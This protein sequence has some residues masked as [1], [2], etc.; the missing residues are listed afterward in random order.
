MGIFIPHEVKG[1]LEMKSLGGT[2]NGLIIWLPCSAFVL[3][4]TI[5]VILVNDQFGVGGVFLLFFVAE[6]P[7]QVYKIIY[8]GIAR[9]R[10]YNLKL[11]RSI[12]NCWTIYLI[13]NLFLITGGL[14][15]WLLSLMEYNTLNIPNS[16]YWTVIILLAVLM[17]IKPIQS[18]AV[19]KIYA[20]KGRYPGKLISAFVPRFFFLYS[21]VV[22]YFYAFIDYSEIKTV[23]PSLCVVYIGIERIISM[24]QI[25]SDYSNDEYYSLFRDTVKWI[26]KRRKID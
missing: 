8:E 25:V 21:F 12:T 17:S 19:K 20:R 24:F 7:L 2:S 18:F 10:L 14:F 1:I 4:M 22:Y 15:S 13:I 5:C 23:I 11:V 3:F 26:K 6:T 9:R 16:V